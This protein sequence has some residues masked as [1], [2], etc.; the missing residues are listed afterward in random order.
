MDAGNAHEIVPE[1]AEMLESKPMRGILLSTEFDST[2]RVRSF[3]LPP[4]DFFFAT[5]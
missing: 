3:F 4:D 1:P 5:F 2:R